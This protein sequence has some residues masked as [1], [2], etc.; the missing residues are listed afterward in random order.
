MPTKKGRKR[1]HATP[2]EKAAAENARLREKR[3]EER[4]KKKQARTPGGD[5][6][7]GIGDDAEEEGDTI[8]QFKN[9]YG[10]AGPASESPRNAAD[11]VIDYLRDGDNYNNF[12]KASGSEKG[13][14]IGE[15]QEDMAHLGMM[16]PMGVLLL[17][18]PLLVMRKCLST[19]SVEAKIACL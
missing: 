7:G 1:K 16:P 15:M 9:D 17:S 3:A 10:R 2:E 18:P 4:E 13:R 11:L 14:M 8:R 12:K 5:D 6:V 19:N